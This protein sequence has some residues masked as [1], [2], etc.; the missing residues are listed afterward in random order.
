MNAAEALVNAHWN[1]EVNGGPMLV[2]KEVDNTNDDPI[3]ASA[4]G[5]TSKISHLARPYK[6]YTRMSIMAVETDQRR[7]LQAPTA[8]ELTCDDDLRERRQ[9]CRD[10]CKLFAPIK[11]VSL[12]SRTLDFAVRG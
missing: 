1:S 9:R 11:A 6:A 3:T 4:S 8:D 5:P 10:L 2:K 7:C 12:P